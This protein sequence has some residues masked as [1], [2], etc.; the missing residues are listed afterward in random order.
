MNEFRATYGLKSLIADPELTILAQTQAENLASFNS[1][2]HSDPQ[3]GASL[4]DRIKNS[5][6]MAETASENIGIGDSH[7][8]VFNKFSR[9]EKHLRNLLDPQMTHVGLG[10]AH[11]ENLV[12]VV[13]DY[14]RKITVYLPKVASERITTVLNETRALHYLQPFHLDDELNRIARLHTLYMIEDDRLF[15]PHWN[16]PMS[17]KVF[18]FAAP[19]LM[20]VVSDLDLDHTQLQSAGIYFQ[21]AKTDSHPM[22]VFWGTV[23]IK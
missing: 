19:D 8:R 1:F 11:V 12:Y 13:Q 3:T 17:Y 22:G 9:S 4:I 2:S 7:L 23:I 15:F 6:L 20:S 10:F 5:N 21:A 18:C 16:G 14:I